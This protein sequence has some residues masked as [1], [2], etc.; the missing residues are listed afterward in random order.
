[1]SAHD[2]RTLSRRE[3]LM[4]AAALAGA[5][6]MAACAPAPPAPAEEE[7]EEEVEEEVEEEEEEAPAEAPAESEGV[8][9]TMWKGP[10]KAAG[11]ETKLCARPTLDIFESTASAFLLAAKSSNRF[12]PRW[13]STPRITALS[14]KQRRHVAIWDF[15]KA[16]SW[17][18]T[19]TAA[20][21]LRRM[22]MACLQRWSAVFIFFPPCSM[23]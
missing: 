16:V 19:L 11:D 3:F 1:M 14:A 2:S 18:S 12:S 5:A 9:L 15:K 17:G 4:R 6:A 8:M 20:W 13:L 10:H 7:M 22:D 23:I 21:R